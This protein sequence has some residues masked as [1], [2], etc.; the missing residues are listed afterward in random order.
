MDNCDIFINQIPF[1]GSS[2]A[3]LDKDEPIVYSLNA[4][5]KT[6]QMC[7][8]MEYF[9]RKSTY[10]SNSSSSHSINV[11]SEDVFDRDFDATSIR[12]GMIRLQFAAGNFQE[13]ARY[14]RPENILTFLIISEIESSIFDKN[15][16][17]FE[18]QYALAR[19]AHGDSEFDV[20]PIMRAAFENIDKGI[21]FLEEERGLRFELMANIDHA[22]EFDSGNLAGESGYLNKPDVLKRA[23]FNSKSYVQT[24]PEN[25]FMLEPRNIP[26]DLGRDDIVEDYDEKLAKVRQ[27]IDD[28]VEMLEDM[29]KKQDDKKSE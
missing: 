6:G 14:Y 16:K 24:T 7:L 12:E 5:K 29:K 8:I 25:D 15:Y 21:A 22:C 18:T 23:L 1:D 27:N 9:I 17:R 4:L 10:E 20:L 11:D 3:S 28:F 19:S 2:R 26:T 13:W